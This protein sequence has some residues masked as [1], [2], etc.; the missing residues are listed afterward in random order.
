[1]IPKARIPEINEFMTGYLVD[2][3]SATASS[4]NVYIPLIMID[5]TNSNV[6]S[7]VGVK[8]IF[9]SAEN[10]RTSSK[11]GSKNYITAKVSP[12]IAHIYAENPTANFKKGAQVRL[13]IPLLDLEQAIVIPM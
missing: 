3:S 6:I 12:V 7:N 4:M 13:Y 10:I 5:K 8:N 11:V 9:V 2:A 1:M